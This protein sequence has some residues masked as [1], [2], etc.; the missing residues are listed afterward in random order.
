MIERQERREEVHDAL[1]KQCRHNVITLGHI[2]KEPD[3]PA[4]RLSAPLCWIRPGLL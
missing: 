2:H 3:A 4:R 1:L